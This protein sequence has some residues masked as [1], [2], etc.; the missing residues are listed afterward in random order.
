MKWETFKQVLGEYLTKLFF[1]LFVLFLLFG[2]IQHCSEDDTKSNQTNSPVERVEIDSV[3]KENDKLIIEIE[4]LDSI[5]NAE[6]I[7]IES[8]SN[9]STLRMFYKLIGKQSY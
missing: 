8:L 6:I 9:D 3:I 1:V 5:K 4:S 2:F 7:K